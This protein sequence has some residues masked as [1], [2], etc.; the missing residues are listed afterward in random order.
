VNVFDHESPVGGLRLVSDGMH[1]VGLQFTDGL[2]PAEASRQLADRVLDEA[3]RQLDAYFAGR[4]KVFE[5]PLGLEGT[6][7]QLR[8]WSALQEIP[9]GETRSYGDL[10]RAIGKPTAT[11]AVGAANGANPISIIV[12]CHR[13]VGADGAL[14]GF[15]GGIE[16]K[17]FLLG[18]EQGRELRLTG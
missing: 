14:T 8:V 12:P 7:F 17:K 3:R 6:P 15:G 1:L 13:V 18:L 11:R 2:P 4:R 9:F 16:R 5:L 10:A